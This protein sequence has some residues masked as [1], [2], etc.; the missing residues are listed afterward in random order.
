MSII[1]LLFHSNPS[2]LS[3]K[4]SGGTV[5]T[6]GNGYVYHV[7]LEP[8]IFSVNEGPIFIESLIVAV[9]VLEDNRQAIKLEEVVLEEF[10]L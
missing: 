10:V 2:P 7:F 3:I 6:P 8:G 1:Q 9:E 4:S 5:Y